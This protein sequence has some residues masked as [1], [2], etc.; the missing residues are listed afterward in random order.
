MKNKAPLSLMEQLIMLLVFALSAAL[1]LQVYVLSS[2]I[3]RRCEAQAHAVTAVQN[4]AEVVKSCKGDVSRYSDLLG[5]TGDAHQWQ[6][7]YSASWDPVS[8]H[9]AAYRVL[10]T[11]GAAPVP[12]LGLATVSAHT[13]AADTLFTVT[14]AWQEVS[15]ETQ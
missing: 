5:G 3:S 15:H 10:V 1:C 6:I 14:V 11:S 13:D 12:G 2:Q 7:G 9:Q 8:L 4:T